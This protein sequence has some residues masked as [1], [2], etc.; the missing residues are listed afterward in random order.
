MCLLWNTVGTLYIAHILQAVWSDHGWFE[1]P[2][3]QKKKKEKKSDDLERIEKKEEQ[4]S[5]AD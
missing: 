2:M 1:G 3:R 4:Q 5:A